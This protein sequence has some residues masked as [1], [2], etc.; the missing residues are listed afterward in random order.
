MQRNIK[1]PEFKIQAG[2]M[3]VENGKVKP[4]P[5]KGEIK[6]SLNA[7]NLLIFEWIDLITNIKSEPLVIFDSEWEWKKQGT[8]KGRVY[9]L[10][11]TTFGEKFYFWMQYPNVAED[12]V[13]MNIISNILK[14]GRLEL[15]EEK[16]AKDNVNN[17]ESFIKAE[18]KESNT[19]NTNIAGNTNNNSKANNADFIK[20]FASSLRSTKK[21]IIS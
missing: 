19:G 18:G 6:F 5:N 3:I 12:E 15:N 11:S 1:K 9:I 8:Q 14:T 16:E 2:Q 21:S 17:V 4:N 7:D 13:N 10:Q 20:S